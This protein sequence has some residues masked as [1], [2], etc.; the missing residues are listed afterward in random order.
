[1]AV[2]EASADETPYGRYIASDGWFVH[3]L[4]DALAVRNEEKGGAMYPLEP[5]E[6]PFG[7]LRR[8]RPGRLARRPQRALPLRGRAGGVSRARGRVHAD[9]RGGGA[10]AAAVGLLP[11]PGRDAARDRRRRR[12]AVRDPHDRRATRGRDTALPG[13]RGRGE[14]RRVRGE[15]TPTSRTRRTPTGRATTCR[16]VF[17]GLPPRRPTPDRAPGAERAAGRDPR[18]ARERAAPGGRLVPLG[19]VRERAA[20]GHRARGLQRRRDGVGVPPARPRPLARLPVG[21]GRPRR[22][23]RR[24]AAPLPRRS[25]SGTAATR[26]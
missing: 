16:C 4:E 10:T 3:N 22:V 7:R 14:V 25:R 15:R 1:M 5:R 6:A 23:L 24:R 21:R 13:E 11:L 12:R 19:P 17:R 20:V 8:Q 18:A 26:S 9:R 2:R